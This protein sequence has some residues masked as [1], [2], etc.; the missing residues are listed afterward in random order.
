MLNGAVPESE[1][2]RIRQITSACVVTNVLHFNVRHC[3]YIV[4][5]KFL[6]WVVIL[7]YIVIVLESYSVL[8]CDMVSKSLIVTQPRVF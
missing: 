5:Y 1:C 4:T 7:C 8:K 6:L 2:R 3:I